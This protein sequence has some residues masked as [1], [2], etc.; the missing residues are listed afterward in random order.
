MADR[1]ALHMATVVERV[2]AGIRESE[3]VEQGVDT[4]RRLIDLLGDTSNE[5]LHGDRPHPDAEM[6]E[7]IVERQMDGSDE[8]IARPH[9][10]LLDSILLTNAPGEPTIGAAL[11][12][13]ID[14]ADHID[15]IM[16]FIRLSGLKPMQAAL[17]RFCQR[18]PENSGY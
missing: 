16:A 1:L 2:L 7:A 15:I 6:L 14:S 4:I 3:R 5:A 17:E 12:S 18:A 13:E 10:P 11:T 8:R 9:V